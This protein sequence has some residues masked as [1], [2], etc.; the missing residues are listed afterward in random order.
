MSETQIRLA[1]IVG[2][3]R[4]GRRAPVVADWFAGEARRSESINGVDVI[5][6]ADA[7]LPET[8]SSTPGAQVI[9]T[10]KRLNAAD[11]VVIVVPEYNHSF[12]A[13]VKTVLDWTSSAWKAKPVGF[14]SYGGRSGGLRA[15]E[16]LRQVLP[17]MHAMSV[18]ESVSFHDVWG[19][20]DAEGQPNEAM[21]CA[22]A[23][24]VMIDRLVWWGL[25]LKDAREKRPY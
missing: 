4:E 25:A 10:A 19:Q 13:A 11:A 7:S 23:A 5:D 9:A 8:L 21:A 1:V 3:T 15:V 20:F 6:L 12:P 16:Q 24:G 22:A 17:E 2:S 18:R 14:V